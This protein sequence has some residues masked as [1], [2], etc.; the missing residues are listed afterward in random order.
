MASDGLKEHTI[1]PALPK[2]GLESTSY[3]GS[4]PKL[5]ECRT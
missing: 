5:F 2:S 1:S 4:S 3:E